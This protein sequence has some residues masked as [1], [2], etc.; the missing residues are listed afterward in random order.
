M[1]VTEELIPPV[2]NTEVASIE[3]QQEEAVVPVP[4]STLDSP[5]A[6]PLD[7]PEKEESTQEQVAQIQSPVEDVGSALEEIKLSPVSH[8][9]DMQNVKQLAHTGKHFHFVF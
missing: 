2:S 7:L 4:Q 8:A 1:D 6:L 9:S 5:L 3:V